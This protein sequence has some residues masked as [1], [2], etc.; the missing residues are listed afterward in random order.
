APE[1]YGRFEPGGTV[2]DFER[3]RTRALADADKVRVEDVD[4]DRRALLD[5]LHGRDDVDPSRVFAAG[6]CF[7]GHLAFRAADEPDVARV[8]CFY[9]TTVHS[10]R[11]GASQS[12]DSLSRVEELR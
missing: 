6:F 1:I 10:E 3:D 5:H 7:G 2:L 9:P 8:A 4:A 11:L 12:V